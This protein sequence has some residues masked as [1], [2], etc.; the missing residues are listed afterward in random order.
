MTSRIL[1]QALLIV[2]TVCVLSTVAAAQQLTLEQLIDEAEVIVRGVVTKYEF[3]R[4][5]GNREGLL[6]TYATMEIREQF[7]G[8]PVAKE[9]VIKSP[10][11][12]EGNIIITG[13]E[14]T[15]PPKGKEVIAFLK[16]RKDGHWR[17]IRGE[18]GCFVIHDG[19]TTRW[20][21]SLDRFLELVQESADRNLDSS[22]VK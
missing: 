8:D 15:V 5:E 20:N 3:K 21:V 14:S 13:T 18:Y 22:E 7:K 1:N 4:E 11:G 19:F 16:I 10:G 17:M 12:M 6:F 2:G 9:I